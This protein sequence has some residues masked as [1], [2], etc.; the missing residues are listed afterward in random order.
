MPHSSKVLHIC[1]QCTSYG[2]EKVFVAGRLV[3]LSLA[4]G[5]P[6][7]PCLADSVLNFLSYGLSDKAMPDIDDIPDPLMKKRLNRVSRP[8]YP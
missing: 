5:G 3:A 8:I 2:S 6:A 4:N 7:F 1:T